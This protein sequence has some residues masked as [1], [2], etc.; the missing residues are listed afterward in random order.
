M[1]L[2]FLCRLVR[3]VVELIRIHSMDAVAKDAEILVV[4]H[5]TGGT[6]EGSSPRGT[7][8][9]IFGTAFT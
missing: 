5:Q 3:R 2:S 8:D 1:A 7:S 4:R 6:P 9:P